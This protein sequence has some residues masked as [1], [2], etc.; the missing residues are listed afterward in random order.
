[1]TKSSEQKLEC[2]YCITNQTNKT[3]T[4][5]TNKYISL[6]KPSK[7]KTK[8]KTKFNPCNKQSLTCHDRK[9]MFLAVKLTG[10]EFQLAFTKTICYTKMRSFHSFHNKP[11]SMIT[12]SSS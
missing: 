10:R 6:K 9:K 5:L 4:K 1:M 8:Q 2:H 7:D 12:Y 3:T 11:D